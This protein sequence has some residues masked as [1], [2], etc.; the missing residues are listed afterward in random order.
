MKL[1]IEGIDGAGKDTFITNLSKKLKE[2]NYHIKEVKTPIE[3][4]SN[5]RKSFGE[6]FSFERFL[7]YIVASLYTDKVL[8]NKDII[9]FNRHTYSS[10]AYPLATLEDNYKK[11][12]EEII[13][14]L[15]FKKADLYVFIK[16]D[17]DTIIERLLERKRNKSNIHDRQLEDEFIE[18]KNF[19]KKLHYLFYEELPPKLMPILTKKSITLINNTPED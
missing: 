15:S 10:I 8:E 7:F 2:L 4:F 6:K 16:A 9:L 18:E 13:K 17:V 12:V 5:I 1:V 19:L 3:P 14:K 11:L